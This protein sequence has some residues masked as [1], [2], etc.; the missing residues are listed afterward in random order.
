MEAYNDLLEWAR[1]KGVELS[2]V[3]PRQIPGRGIGMVATEK[4][5]V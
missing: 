1:N 5:Q 3:E 4:L 2:G